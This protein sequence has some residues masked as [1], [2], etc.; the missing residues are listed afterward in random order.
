M[1]LPV[2]LQAEEWQGRWRLSVMIGGRRLLTPHEFPT[3]DALEAAL[4][5]G[6]L[7]LSEDTCS[8]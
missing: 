4:A 8:T 2:E 6:L 7:K 1:V 5:K 3:R